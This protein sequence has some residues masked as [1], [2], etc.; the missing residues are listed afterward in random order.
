M[1]E[2]RSYGK[3]KPEV[4]EKMIDNIFI[5]LEDGDELTFAFQGGEP[6]LAGLSYFQHFVS[7]PYTHLTL[8]TNREV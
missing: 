6:T 2:V 8:P 4:T 3:M 1:R 5:D 7:V